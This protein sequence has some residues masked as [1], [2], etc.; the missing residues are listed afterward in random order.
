MKHLKL[1]AVLLF[2]FVGVSVLVAGMP[3][4]AADNTSSKEDETLSEE[5]ETI[6]EAEFERLVAES[7][8]SKSDMKCLR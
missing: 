5:E 3:I 4:F 7:A 2:I 8:L 6:S 1:I